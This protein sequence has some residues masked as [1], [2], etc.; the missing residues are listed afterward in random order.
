MKYRLIIGILSAYGFIT[1]PLLDTSV[2]ADEEQI[3]EWAIGPFLRPSGA[4]PIISPQPTEFYCPMQKQQIRWEESDTFN[5]A[6]TMKNG[7]LLFF[8]G[9]RIVRHRALEK[10]ITHWLC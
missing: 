10:D 9:Q 5:P 1:P 7:K 6:A 2:I 8:I 3:K 4:N